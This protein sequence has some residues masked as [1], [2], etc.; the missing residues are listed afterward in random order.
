MLSLEFNAFKHRNW[1]RFMNTFVDRGYVKMY[2]YRFQIGNARRPVPVNLYSLTNHGITEYHTQWPATP[3]VK[4]NISPVVL[5]HNF[6][7]LRVIKEHLKINNPYRYFLPSG[8]E[9]LRNKL[10]GKGLVANLELKYIS[11]DKSVDFVYLKTINGNDI[12]IA[13][14]IELTQKAK[15]RY[16]GS[17]NRTTV[18]SKLNRDYALGMFNELEYYVPRHLYSPIKNIFETAPNKYKLQMGYKIFILEN[19]LPNYVYQER[20]VNIYK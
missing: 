2:R 8:M 5:S 18:F 7:C 10:S 6:V 4:T 9:Y 11:A 13:V 19:V 20:Y 3:W 12:K 14:E 17:K 16:Y 15:H 1:I